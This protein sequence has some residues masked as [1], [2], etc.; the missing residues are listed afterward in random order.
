MIYRKGTDM[1]LLAVPAGKKIPNDVNVIIEIPMHSDPVKYEVDKETGALFVDR[2]MSTA[3]YYPANYG[4]VPQTLSQDGDPVDVLVVAPTPLVSGS[5]VRSRPV[6]VLKMTDESG[7]DAKIIAVPV[8][9]LCKAYQDV[10]TLDDLPQG[11]LQA[12][13]H[14][15]EHYKDLE[16][17]KWVKVDGFDGP[18][19]AR[20]EIE[21]SIERYAQS[22]ETVV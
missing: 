15:F 19:A 1:S 11:L 2:F 21:D 8:T 12:I 14:F 22:L 4:Y 5:V 20:Q 3:M 18:D 16:E 10:E 13:T 17:G 7:I 6:G 9:K